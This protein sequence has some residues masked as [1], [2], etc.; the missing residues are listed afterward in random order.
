MTRQTGAVAT[1]LAIDCGG[2]GIKASVLDEGGT[3]RSRPLRV[4]TPYP[5]PPSL[6]VK[7]LVDLGGQ[8]PPAERVTVGMPGMIRHGVVVATPHYVTRSGPRTKIDLELVAE[9]AGFDAQ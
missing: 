8:L 3:M 1:T 9:W 7:T 2:G 4:P 5:L 6:F